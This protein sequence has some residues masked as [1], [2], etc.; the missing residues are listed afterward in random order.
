MS[1]QAFMFLKILAVAVLLIWPAVSKA[2]SIHENF[3]SLTAAL[4]H[5][6]PIGAFMVTSGSVDVVG[7]GVFG[8]LC[9]A[10]ES[11]N[12]VD[13][14]GSTGV[15]GQISS[16]ILT[17]TPGT[18]IFSFDLIGSQR[19][20]DTSTTVTLGSLFNHTYLLSS[21]DVASGIVNATIIVGTTTVAPLIFT[22]N[23]SG[24][25]GALLDNVT[26][27]SVPEPATLSLLGIGLVGLMF[28]RRRAAAAK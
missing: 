3:D 8:S 4:N 21:A 23:T 16:A 17:L 20:L 6:N 22:S 26:L 15:A 28:G 13:L 14:D 25:I 19:G 1:R 12:C 18:Y 7:D 5:A 27:V 10:P 11:G 24:N 2:D 9:V